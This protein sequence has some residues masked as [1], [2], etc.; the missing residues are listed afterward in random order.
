MHINLIN[1]IEL[2]H[3]ME[4]LRKE[5]REKAFFALPDFT[6]IKKQREDFLV[7]LRKTK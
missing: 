2:K 7:K 4:D 5:K 6:M 3:K 1:K